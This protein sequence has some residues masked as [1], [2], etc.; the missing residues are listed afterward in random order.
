M[1]IG[2]LPIHENLNIAR[3]GY[4]QNSQLACEFERNMANDTLLREVLS[5]KA[6]V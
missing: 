4:S 5:C 2:V 1:W 6:K 3:K